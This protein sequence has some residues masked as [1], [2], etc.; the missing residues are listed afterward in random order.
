M[1]KVTIFSEV[2][3]QRSCQELTV[4]FYIHDHGHESYFNG[5]SSWNP[6]VIA[7]ESEGLYRCTD[8]KIGK[9]SALV[10]VK[11]QIKLC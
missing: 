11:N 7:L 9:I 4:V 5:A 1:E 8:D 10:D 2:A 6:E 3:T